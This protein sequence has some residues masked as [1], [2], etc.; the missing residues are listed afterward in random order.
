M[1]IEGEQ[2]GRYH[3]IIKKCYSDGSADYETRFSDKNDLMESAACIRACI[4]KAVGLGT[5]CAK[6][7]VGVRIIRGKENIRKELEG[8]E[9]ETQEK[10]RR[11]HTR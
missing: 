10:K 3:A 11:K 4:G 2:I 7:L 5:D 9:E 6:V 8:R 1:K